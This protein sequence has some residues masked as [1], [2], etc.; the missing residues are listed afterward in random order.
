MLGPKTTQPLETYSRSEQTKPFGDHQD[1]PPTM[2]VGYLIRFQGRL[3]PFSNTGTVQDI[4]FHVQGRTYQ[5]KSTFFQ[6]VHCTHG[7]HCSSKELKLMAIHKGI[8]IHQYLDHWLVKATSHRGCLR[9][10][11]DLVKICQSLGYQ[12]DLMA[13][14]VRPI[15]DHWQNLQDKIQEILSLPICPVQQFMS[16]RLT[17][18]HGKAFSPRPTS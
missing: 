10:T 4:K 3:L 14:Q 12:F 18:S 7:A 17:I 5:F 1:H 16:D 15:P 13:G 2:R 6:S 9:H 8:I 11:L